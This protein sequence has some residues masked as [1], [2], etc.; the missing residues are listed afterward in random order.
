MTHIKGPIKNICV[1]V[2][3]ALSVLTAP[4]HAAGRY[5]DIVIDVNTNA[6]LHAEN[7]DAAL[8]PASLTKMMTLYMTFAALKAG[9]LTETMLLPVSKYATTAGPTKLGLHAGSRISVK[10]AI[11]GLVTCSANDAARVLAEAIG[12]N[13]PHFASMMTQQAKRLGMKR[14]AF[15]NASGLPDPRQYSSAR[16][17]AQLGRA[18]L[19]SFPDYYDYFSTAEFSYGGKTYANHNHL[20]ERYPG[21]DGLKTGFV[22]ASGFNLVAS[23][24]RFDHRLVGVV[25]GGA[26]ARGRDDQMADL[27]DQAF[28]DVQNPANVVT[29]KQPAPPNITVA[30]LQPADPRAAAPAMT[31]DGVIAVNDNSDD[32]ET[33]VRPATSTAKYVLASAAPVAAKIALKPTKLKVASK[34]KLKTKDPVVA[35]DWGI[36]VGAYKDKASSQSAINQIRNRNS[37]LLQQARADVSLIKTHS[38]HLYRAR[39]VNLN[40]STAEAACGALKLQGRTCI[41]LPPAS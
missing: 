21:M 3:L 9:K 36:Q 33:P 27:L 6:I 17:M 25:F 24:V 34:T 13:E 7:A 40:Q 37:R 32:D 41:T 35:R 31:P 1:V 28:S 14:T 29:A 8:H 11:L 15:Y 26:S 38:G 2:I 18:L 10:N 19:A 39:I 22:N 12:G 5:A 30:S 16:D 23:A 20:M 4:A